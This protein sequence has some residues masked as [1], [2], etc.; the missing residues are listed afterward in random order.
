MLGFRPSKA[1]YAAT[2]RA[3]ALTHIGTDQ[4]FTTASH[5]RARRKACMRAT[6]R[7]ITPTTR[8]NVFWLM[9]SPPPA[10]RG[11]RGTLTRIVPP[12]RQ[13]KRR[14]C[15]PKAQ[16]RPY[17]PFPRHMYY[18]DGLQS[19]NQPRPTKPGER[20]RLSANGEPRPT[21]AD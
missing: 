18:I 3:R 2:S 1:K 7:K 8:E 10:E 15:P 5:L 19:A 4:P 14:K 17:C 21:A 20:I 6:R 11:D 12:P 16:S 13:K 9:K